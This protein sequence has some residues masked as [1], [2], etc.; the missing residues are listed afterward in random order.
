[1]SII[2]LLLL[3]WNT[4]TLNKNE[5][6]TFTFFLEEKDNVRP[7]RRF[8]RGDI[9]LGSATS[10]KRLRSSCKRW[11]SLFNNRRFTRKH[12]HKAEKQYRF[13]MSWANKFR[14]CSI[15]F[16]L[17]GMPSIELKG[18]ISLNNN[19]LLLSTIKKKGD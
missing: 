15:S 12:F 9:L 16:N 3:K 19:G 6:C 8:G 2:C 10:L 14:V 11:D 18:E 4:K 7:S 1:M 17:H 13:L 5:S